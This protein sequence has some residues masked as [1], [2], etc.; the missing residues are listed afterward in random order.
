[1]QD[2]FY[3]RL[4]FY[5]MLHGGMTNLAEM[6]LTLG[7]SVRTLERWKTAYDPEKGPYG[8]LADISVR[9]RLDFPQGSLEGLDGQEDLAAMNG[10][11]VRRGSRQEILWALRRIALEGNVPAAKVVLEELAESDSGGSDGDEI[12]TVEKAV[13]LLREWEAE[14]SSRSEDLPQPP[15]LC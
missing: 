3:P 1:M 14:R 6:A 8:S 5:R 9:D 11:G 2:T 15:P 7:V 12:L 4:D 10:A 13:E